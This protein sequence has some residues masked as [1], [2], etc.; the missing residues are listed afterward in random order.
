M[1]QVFDSNVNKD[2]LL[3][4]KLGSGKVI[5]VSPSRLPQHPATHPVGLCRSYLLT[6]TVLL[7]FFLPLF[8]FHPQGW[9]EGMVGMKKSGRRL[10]VIPPT[11]AYGSKGL[12]GRIPADSTLVFEVEL[13]RVRKYG[14]LSSSTN[15]NLL[16]MLT[17]SYL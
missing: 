2:K 4:M 5:K 6:L 11:L 9:D 7:S 17:H 1:L 3:R 8:V 16:E 12:A 10:M 13:R 14:P 15:V